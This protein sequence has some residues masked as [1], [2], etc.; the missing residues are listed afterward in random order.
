M[1]MVVVSFRVPV[2][3]ESACVSTTTLISIAGH[4]GP[5][6]R[7]VAHARDRQ[8]ISDNSV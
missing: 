1:R 5:A 7:L 2:L 4:G 8:V 6:S 3:V